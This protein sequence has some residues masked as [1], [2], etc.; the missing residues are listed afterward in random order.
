[1]VDTRS[2]ELS[3]VDL[4]S[5]RKT[6]ARQLAPSI[7]NLAFAP[8]GTIYVSNFA[9]NAVHAYHPQTGELRTL[10]SGKLAVPGGIALEGDTLWVADLFIFRRVDV[11]S[12]EVRDIHRMNASDL[13]YPFTVALNDRLFALSSVFSGSVHLID[14]ATVRTAAKLHGLKAPTDALLL[15]DGRLA[16]IE[17]ATGALTLARG[18][19][20]RDDKLTL[21]KGLAQT[22]WGSFIVGEGAARRLVEIDATAGTRRTVAEDLPLVPTGSPPY[23]TGLA[24]ADDT[25]Y[26]TADANNA[27]YRLRPRR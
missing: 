24:V 8:D 26:M 7:D 4:A 22:P 13:E 14:R 18:A 11:R 20:Y 12:G 10:T 1:M 21:P 5:G 2:G 15:R 9:E 17:I 3:R 6:V 16:F 23:P 25:I 19:D 27:L